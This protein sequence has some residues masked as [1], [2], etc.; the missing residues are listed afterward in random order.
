[1]WSGYD[2]SI[3]ALIGNK[4]RESIFVCYNLS[5][6]SWNELPFNSNWTSTD[7]GASL[8]WTGGEY[9][10]A[11]RGEYDE[12]APN[13]DF[14]RYYIPNG[15]WEDMSPMPESEGVGDGAS[16]LWTE[17]YPEHILSLG[18]GSCLEDPGYNF[19]G[20]DIASN[21][22]QELNSL[23]CPVGYY[24]GNRLGVVNGQRIFY[25]QGAPATW[26]CGG[27]AFFMFVIPQP[28]RQGTPIIVEEKKIGEAIVSRP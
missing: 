1:M 24:V 4:D 2:G 13:G 10:Y 18:G 20:Y 8:V 26:I 28:V 6:D 23:P 7:D 27:D 17:S 16:L 14:A 15:T 3:Y 5:N 25:W 22:W 11:L 12:T 21:E 19:Y 9:L